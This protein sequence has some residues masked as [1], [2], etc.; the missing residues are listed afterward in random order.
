MQKWG[1]KTFSMSENNVSTI[2]QAQHKQRKLPLFFWALSSCKSLVHTPSFLYIYIYKKKISRALPAD[3]LKKTQ[4]IQHGGI[5]WSSSPS[6]QSSNL[7]PYISSKPFS[8]YARWIGWET[9][10][11]NRTH[12]AYTKALNSLTLVHQNK[13]VRAPY[14]KTDW[15]GRSRRDGGTAHG[16]GGWRRRRRPAPSWASWAAARPPEAAAAGSSPPLD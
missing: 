7:S 11:K 12:S 14:P 15:S 1:K 8:S 6:S 5:I 10:Y 13:H 9:K 16:A 3:S 4:S 2:I